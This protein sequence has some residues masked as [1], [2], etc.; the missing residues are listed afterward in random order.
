[1]S[2]SH[3]SVKNKAI[4][5]RHGSITLNQG[6]AVSDAPLDIFIDR[7]KLQL[8]LTAPLLNFNDKGYPGTP[9]IA[10][11]IYLKGVFI[12]N[13]IVVPHDLVA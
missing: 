4:I 9:S 1:M 6:M 8:N 11:G 2:P 3:A 13:G 7:G 5:V 10:E 12:V